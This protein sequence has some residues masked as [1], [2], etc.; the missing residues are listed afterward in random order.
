VPCLILHARL[1]QLSGKARYVL[2]G[3]ASRR[4]VTNCD[5]RLGTM[6]AIDD[7]SGVLR[8]WRYGSR[9]LLFD[10]FFEGGF[11]LRPAHEDSIDEKSRCA[12]DA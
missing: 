10:S 11:G 9:E 4:Y 8:L 1:L 2:K 7:E 3:A 6:R 12:A 5:L